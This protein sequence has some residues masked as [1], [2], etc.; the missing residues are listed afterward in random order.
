MGN[1]KQNE[2][3]KA[4]CVGEKAKEVKEAKKFHF[5]GDKKWHPDMGNNV[6]FQFFDTA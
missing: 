1:R 5:L 2:L 4:K 6:E 3:K